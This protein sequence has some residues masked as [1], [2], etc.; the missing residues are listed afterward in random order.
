MKGPE[1]CGDELGGRLTA[2]WASS[3]GVP[4]LDV[5]VKHTWLTAMGER[6]S[7]ASSPGRV[8]TFLESFQG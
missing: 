4:L 3:N 2:R 7:S 5:L 8:V 1:Q 6:A